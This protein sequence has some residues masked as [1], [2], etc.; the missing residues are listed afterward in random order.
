MKRI[1]SSESPR[2]VRLREG[3]REGDFRGLRRGMEIA[4]ESVAGWF[5]MPG[6]SGV[7]L[8]SICCAQDKLFGCAAHEVSSFIQDDEVCSV[9]RLVLIW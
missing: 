7:R 3:R 1:Y 4:G 2:R 8:G 6:W 9:A 5:E